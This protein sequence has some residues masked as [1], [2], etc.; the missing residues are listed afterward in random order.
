VIEVL[1]PDDRP[2]ELLER[3]G[4]YQGAIHMAAMTLETGLVGTVDFQ[5]LFAQLAEP[6]E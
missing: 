5:S 4:D 1:P 2:G 3:I 6:G